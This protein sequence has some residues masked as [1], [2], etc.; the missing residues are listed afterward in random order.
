MGKLGEKQM[1]EKKIS[2]YR[3]KKSKDKQWIGLNKENSTK[4]NMSLKAKG[5]LT[6]ML[7]KPDNW[8][9]YISAMAAELKENRETIS[10]IIDELIKFGYIVKAKKPVINGQYSGYDFSVYETPCPENRHGFT[11]TEKPTL[12]TNDLTKELKNEFEYDSSS[13]DVKDSTKETTDNNLDHIS[14]LVNDINETGK[15]R[16]DRF[17][18]KSECISNL[19]E[20]HQKDGNIVSEI[21]HMYLSE[22]K[23]PAGDLLHLFADNAA[24]YYNIKSKI[25]ETKSKEYVNEVRFC[26]D[27]NSVLPADGICDNP[28]FSKN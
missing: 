2:I 18:L 24:W 15:I 23:N 14:S 8:E 13:L 19:K 11:D 20:Y 28:Y 7:S 17:K 12:L 16:N 26:P 25:E 22:R 27:C 1:A 3:V 4:K 21:V 6:F 9:F 5:L 10:K